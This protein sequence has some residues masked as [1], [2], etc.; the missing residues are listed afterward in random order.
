MQDYKLFIAGEKTRSP[1]AVDADNE[2]GAENMELISLY[3]GRAVKF[4]KHAL[5]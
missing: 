2:L 1:H 4:T 3:L 5:L